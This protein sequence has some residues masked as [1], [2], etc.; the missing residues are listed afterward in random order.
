VEYDGLQEDYAWEK[1]DKSENSLPSGICP[2]VAGENDPGRQGDGCLRLLLD[3]GS[4]VAEQ[5]V[6][7][8]MAVRRL[9]LSSDFVQEQTKEPILCESVA[10]RTERRKSEAQKVGERHRKR[11][12]R[13]RGPA[14]D[15]V[16]HFWAAS[17]LKGMFPV[18]K[19]FTSNWAAASFLSP[20][21]SRSKKLSIEECVSLFK[22][23]PGHRS[24]CRQSSSIA[25][26]LVHPHLR[27]RYDACEPSWPS[28][29]RS[30]QRGATFGG[31]RNRCCHNRSFV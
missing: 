30:K 19:A 25:A 20:E 29:V 28:D 12:K 21:S 4:G 17:D 23:G 27:H 18:A 15:D 6:G 26:R 31:I 7:E 24:R 11:E 5:T 8:N 16:R 10:K 22:V 2:T 3:S 13:E 14:G 1:S 9:V